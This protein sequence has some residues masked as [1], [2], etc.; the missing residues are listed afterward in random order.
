MKQYGANFATE[1]SRKQIGVIYGMA[2]RGEL[3]VEK[4]VMSELYDLADFY[5][6][7]DNRSVA[8]EE[9]EVQ[10][11]LE[12][13]FAKDIEEAQAKIDEFTE[14][15]FALWSKKNQDAADHSIVA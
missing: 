12:S 3:K 15:T 8:R 4:W 9:K 11:I 10:S 1:I 2:K 5:G 14:K 7:D 13:V 6:Y